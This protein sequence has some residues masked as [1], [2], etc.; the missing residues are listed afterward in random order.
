MAC[1][2][3]SDGVRWL[4]RISL[5][6]VKLPRMISLLFLCNLSLC[7][8]LYRNGLLIWT[9]QISWSFAYK[10][11]SRQVRAGRAIDEFHSVQR[12]KVGLYTP[13]TALPRQRGGNR[14]CALRWTTGLMILSLC[15]M[16]LPLRAA[17]RI[18]RKLMPVK[19]R[20]MKVFSLRDG[21]SRAGFYW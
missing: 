1:S 3:T 13:V 5:L 12:S 2:E 7:L 6:L 9:L 11:P 21:F 17:R 8:C 14:G 16:L 18:N 19:C 4:Q 15:H 10:L 20:C